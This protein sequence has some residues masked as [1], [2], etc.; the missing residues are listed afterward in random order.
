MDNIVP[1]TWRKI[2][3][4]RKTKDNLLNARSPRLTQRA[5]EEYKI[6]HKEGNRSARTDK[7]AFIEEL[8]N[9]AETA[10]AKWEQSTVYKI[11]KQLRGQKNTCNKLNQTKISKENY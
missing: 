10:A 1:E 3:E 5:K 8:A 11:T 7:W 2:D 9:E 6:K 4:R